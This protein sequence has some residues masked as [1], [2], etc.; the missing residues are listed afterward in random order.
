MSTIQSQ[1][2]RSKTAHITQKRFIVFTNYPTRPTQQEMDDLYKTHQV[3]H[4]ILSVFE[5]SQ[6]SVLDNRT[7]S[8][9][10]DVDYLQAASQMSNP[11][12]FLLQQIEQA[13]RASVSGLNPSHTDVKEITAAAVV[14]MIIDF[15]SQS[16]GL[17]CL[18]MNNKAFNDLQRSALGSHHMNDFNRFHNDNT[19]SIFRCPVFLMKGGEGSDVMMFENRSIRYSNTIP[20]TF[21][22]EAIFGGANIYKFGPH[23]VEILRRISN[24][25]KD[26]SDNTNPKQNIP[27]NE[28]NLV[29]V[30]T[31][32]VLHSNFGLQ[33]KEDAL[34][35][36]MVAEN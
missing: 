9:V 17:P 33:P 20:Q 35:W 24:I 28:T 22:D 23:A 12:S 1:E 4:S 25:K 18:I 16:G 34:I 29:L 15:E 7:Y 32:V 11:A 26:I 27:I 14:G 21:F 13:I 30:N 2:S 19:N 10:F 6:W 36:K 31:Q 3:K 8:H 5:R